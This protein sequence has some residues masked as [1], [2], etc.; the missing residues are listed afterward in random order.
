MVEVY[1]ILRGLE[2]TDEV[3][4]IRGEW[5]GQEDIIG[6]YSKQLETF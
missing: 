2:G 4:K 6:N 5:E 3:K 1:Q